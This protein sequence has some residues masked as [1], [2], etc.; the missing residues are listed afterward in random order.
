[1]TLRRLRRAFSRS[2]E[3]QLVAG[4]AFVLT[5]LMTLLILDLT[6]KQKD[7]LFDRIRNRV[8]FL[9][10]ALALSSQHQVLTHDLP[11][12]EVIARSF[13]ADPTLEFVM[14][15]DREGRVLGHSD[16]AKVGQYLL[17]PESR[18]LLSGNPVSRLV[19]EGPRSLVGISPI[20]AG[21]AA[22]RQVGWAWISLDLSSV[23][24]H[25]AEVTRAGIIYI[26]V[27]I[28]IGGLFAIALART[29]M[30][31]VKSLLEGTD[32]VARGKL[33]EPIAVQSEN[34]LGRVA[35]AFNEAMEKIRIQQE[36]LHKNVRLR[37][38]FLMI[39]SHELKTP[40]TPL[41]LLLGNLE[42][43][44]ESKDR[45]E[46]APT[47]LQRIKG[48][49]S[50]AARMVNRLTE[51]INLLLD[52][53]RISTGKMKLRPERFN[54]SPLV[55]AVVDGFAPE[56][57]R[58]NCQ[59]SL[60]LPEEITA[61]WDRMRIE[62]VLS[63]LISNAMKYGAGKP[64]EIAVSAADSVAR[65]SVRDHGIGIRETD[66]ERIFGRFE[67]A[68]SPEHFA[69]FGLGLY[70]SRQI[71]AAHGGTI[72]AEGAAGQGSIFIVELPLEPEG[73]LSIA[74]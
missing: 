73:L 65:L 53:S 8:Q 54:V 5:V 72:R 45:K 15:T 50:V 39:A 24:H 35:R 41:K 60:S 37:D 25:F 3:R 43:T 21:G 67:R 57:R 4:V 19:H 11:E 28:A 36:E 16:P 30:R 49:L 59:V 14:I 69:G 31:P 56:L 23:H 52:V 46:P 22:G 9:A 29:V 55:R 63:N 7:F 51:L 40:L 66:R 17:D 18:A 34:E 2:L 27:A 1:M 42:R 38:E 64:I 47:D 74:A 6:R 26:L 62:Q 70:I 71:V 48:S 32:R 12:I 13:S 44:L 58:V 68:A 20:V 61:N 33:D 10:E